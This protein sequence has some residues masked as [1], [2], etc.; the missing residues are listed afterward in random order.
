MAESMLEVRFPQS[1]PVDLTGPSGK[2]PH[3]ARQISGLGVILVANIDRNSDRDS[4][5]GVPSIRARLP[6]FSIIRLS[7]ERFF[8]VG[9]RSRKRK[10]S[11]IQ[12]VARSTISARVHREA[13]PL[14]DTDSP[15]HQPHSSLRWWVPGTCYELL[16]ALRRR[17]WGVADR[18]ASYI[19]CN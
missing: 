7:T 16:I 1:T 5:N 19:C 11:G 9:D 8:R 18:T 3:R 15:W 2:E 6:L 17:S 13:A 10:S 14:A 4:A 12:D